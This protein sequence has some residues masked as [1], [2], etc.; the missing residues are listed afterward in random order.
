MTDALQHIATHPF[1][2][3]PLVQEEAQLLL[4]CMFF[5]LFS[6]FYPFEPKIYIFCSFAI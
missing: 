1:W 5:L 2:D 4:D 3:S 6:F